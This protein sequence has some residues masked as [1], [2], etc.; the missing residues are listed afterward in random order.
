[1]KTVP[2]AVAAVVACGLL[3]FPNI[4]SSDRALIIGVGQYAIA[5]QN[6]P[7]IDRDVEAA[8]QVANALRYDG[9]IRVLRDAEATEARAKA[10]IEWLLQAAPTERALLYFSGHGTQIADTNGDEPDGRDEALV[11]YDYGRAVAGKGAITDDWLAQQLEQ[12]R[13]REVVLLIDSCYS[14]TITRAMRGGVGDHFYFKRL[15]YE[16]PEALVVTQ[17][18][19]GR[20]AVSIADDGAGRYVAL[21]AVEEN[22]TAPASVLGSP[23]TIALRQVVVPAGS[24]PEPTTLRG[25]RDRVATILRERYAEKSYNPQLTGNQA[26]MDQ[27]LTE[28]P[29]HGPLWTGL[30]RL[31]ARSTP[32]GVRLGGVRKSYSVG[33]QAQ[34]QLDLERGGYLLLVSINEADDSVIVIPNKIV[35]EL[36]L[37]KGSHVLP[38]VVWT[39]EPDAPRIRIVASRPGQILVAAI[40]MPDP[41]RVDDPDPAGKAVGAAAPLSPRVLAELERRLTAGGGRNFDVLVEQDQGSEVVTRAEAASAYTVIR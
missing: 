33:E 16:G 21:T 13:A 9:E 23:F 15:P 14:G 34:F 20:P 2:I 36:K 32:G 17:S 7:G 28:P 38:D 22:Q 31:V 19:L 29:A 39:G 30:E 18:P 40:V 41:V 5:T 25:V 10:E 4:A 3:A 37:G 26:L 12:A 6:L 1:M 35:K 8:Q 27:P 11:M 24:G